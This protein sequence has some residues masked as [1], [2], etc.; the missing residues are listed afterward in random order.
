M[1]FFIQSRNKGQANLFWK[2]ISSEI[3]EGFQALDLS[4][5]DSCGNYTF[6][7]PKVLQQGMIQKNVMFVSGL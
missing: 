4:I 2:I 3:E 7:K 1:F 5:W 6:R